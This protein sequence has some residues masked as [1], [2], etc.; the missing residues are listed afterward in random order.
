VTSSHTPPLPRQ[1]TQKRKKS[2]QALSRDTNLAKTVCLFSTP[3]MEEILGASGG[4]ARLAG[5][6]QI[7]LLN[8]KPSATN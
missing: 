2:L 8:A 3:A 6:R 5:A 7:L 4:L 1:F